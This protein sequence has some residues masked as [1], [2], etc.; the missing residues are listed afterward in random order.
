MQLNK[1]NLLKMFIFKRSNPKFK[2]KY[3]LHIIWQKMVCFIS[4]Y[5][6]PNMSFLFISEFIRNLCHSRFL[7]YAFYF[8]R[9]ET[10]RYVFD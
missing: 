2:I 6:N 9:F 4:V 1:P 10:H 5:M 3:I 7:V 8:I